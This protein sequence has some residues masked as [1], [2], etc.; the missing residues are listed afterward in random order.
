[1][2]FSP[3]IFSRPSTV[4][5]L[6]VAAIAVSSLVPV[7]A[8]A[9]SSPVAEQ[10]F[11]EGQRLLSAGKIHEACGKHTAQ[12]HDHEMMPREALSCDIR[13]FAGSRDRVTPGTKRI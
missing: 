3:S 5:T 13:Q 4:R 12:S 7:P 1:M 8:R 11:Q 10:L 2:F 9:Q 6:A